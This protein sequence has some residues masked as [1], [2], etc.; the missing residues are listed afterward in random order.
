MKKN[1]RNWIIVVLALA[2]AGQT[3]MDWQ[4]AA[5]AQNKTIAPA[6]SPTPPPHA[7]HSMPEE[8]MAD[9][10]ASPFAKGLSESMR[11]MH[12]EMMKPPMTG[13]ND[14]DFLA[15]MIPHHQGAI[16]M[17]K[18]VLLY[19]KD[20]RTRRLAQGIIIEQQSEIEAMRRR[21]D[22]IDNKWEK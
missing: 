7:H 2:L 13:N 11:V 10:T 3:L 21:L 16:D 19:G 9:N 4:P 17:A 6:V 5:Q 8:N 12:E 14:R 1:Y 20:E 18:L 22:E 15:T